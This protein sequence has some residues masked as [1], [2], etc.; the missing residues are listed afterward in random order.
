MQGFCQQEALI[1]VEKL[2]QD[3]QV[4]VTALK[5][6]HPGIY[7]YQSE[8]TFNQHQQL[9]SSRIAKPMTAEAFY[10]LEMPLIAAL[11]CGHTKWHRKDQPDNRYPFRE[12]DLFPLQLYFA[13]NRAFVVRSYL[14]QEA[15]KPGT[16]ITHINGNSIPVIIEQLRRYITIDGNVQ[17][18]LYAELNQSFNGYYASF[19]DSRTS[20]EIGY[21]KGGK[22]T[23]LKLPKVSLADIR[24]VTEEHKPAA[25]P[26][27]ELTLP[28]KDIAILRI[29]RF[30]P[31]EGDPDFYKF[32]DSA[33]L[34][35]K[36]NA[37]STLIIDLRN[38]EG[39]VEEYGGYLYSYLATAPFH[40]YKKIRVAR[41]TASS[42]KQYTWFPQGYEQ[43][44]PMIRQKDGE[45]LWPMQEYLAE[46]PAK[47]N[48]FGGKVLI[49]INGS[50][51]SVTA[52]FAAV[53]KTYDRALFIG[54]ETGGAYEGDNSGVFAIVNLSNSGLAVS[55]PLMSFY[56]HT[57]NANPAASGILPGLKVVASVDDIIAGKDVVME[58]AMA[59]AE[60]N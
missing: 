5:E 57:S 45:Y 43:A 36:K 6:L 8:A 41:N 4:L 11:H 28:K 50:S 49:L 18:S 40:Y 42:V 34:A 19:I 33:F 44:L 30:Y 55:V 25:R 10:R 60:K 16:E 24:R 47:E 7:R 52:E 27:M 32:I 2:R 22:R 53:A 13:D 48:A 51:F 23:T 37:V 17:S 58:K 14:P 31:G 26:S 56:M 46:K 15:I 3:H 39:G 9:I 21:G 29:D 20:Y 54:E 35:I 59:E 12:N 38:N 1:P